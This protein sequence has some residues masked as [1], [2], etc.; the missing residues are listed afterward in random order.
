MYYF[1]RPC[2]NCHNLYSTSMYMF[3]GIFIEYA[4]SDCHFSKASYK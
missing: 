3:N 4:F 2:D 1:Q